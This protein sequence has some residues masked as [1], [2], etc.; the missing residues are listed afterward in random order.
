MQSLTGLHGVS[1]GC[2]TKP[3]LTSYCMCLNTM[4]K[5]TITLYRNYIQPPSSTYNKPTLCNDD[6]TEVFRDAVLS[7]SHLI[8]MSY[9]DARLGEQS[10]F[11]HYEKHP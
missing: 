3:C 8:V 9:S 5:A 1:R 4:D 7:H 10:F 6:N 11:T 2:L